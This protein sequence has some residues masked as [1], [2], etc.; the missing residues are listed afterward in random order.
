MQ[1]NIGRTDDGGDGDVIDILTGLAER[2]RIRRLPLTERLIW[3]QRFMELKIHEVA[4]NVN[5]GNAIFIAMQTERR[6]SFLGGW[7]R[8]YVDG[9]EVCVFAGNEITNPIGQAQGGCAGKRCKV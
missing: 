5:F 1:H 9:K 8:F 2:K 7:A 6:Q 3:L 4:P